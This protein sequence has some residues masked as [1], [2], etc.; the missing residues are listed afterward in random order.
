MRAKRSCRMH[1]HMSFHHMD[2]WH[3]RSLLTARLVSEC[4]A[5]LGPVA[6]CKGLW[7]PMSVGL[8][9]LYRVLSARQCL[10]CL[11]IFLTKL[12]SLNRLRRQSNLQTVLRA[13]A[14]HAAVWAISTA[15]QRGVALHQWFQA[16]T[17]TFNSNCASAADEAFC[18]LLGGPHWPP[19]RKYEYE[20][21]D[22][23]SGRCETR[24]RF[25]P[26]GHT[27]RRLERVLRLG[28]RPHWS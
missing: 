3:L 12:N 5:S 11:D 1:T 24:L 28:W 9:V 10:N 7:G 26:R 17:H 23:M 15:G 27:K 18:C 19:K 4:A 8:R 16:T 14:V 25:F 20:L 21:S 22:L 13:V 6:M 2:A